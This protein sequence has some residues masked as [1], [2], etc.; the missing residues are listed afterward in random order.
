MK[1]IILVFVFAVLIFTAGPAIEEAHAFG[2]G[3]MGPDPTAL[4]MRVADRLIFDIGWY[5]GVYKPFYYGEHGASLI[6]FI[7]DYWIVNPQIADVFYFYAGIGGRL[8]ISSVDS[9][10]GLGLRIP[11]GFQIL[12]PIEQIALEIFLEFAPTVGFLPG[13]GVGIDPAIGLRINF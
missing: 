1:K 4:T 10:F 7:L 11:L 9:A 13:I 2:I 5:F 8:D 6:M 3:V 12:I